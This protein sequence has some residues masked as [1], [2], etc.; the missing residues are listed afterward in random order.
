MGIYGFVVKMECKM[1]MPGQTTTLI[2]NCLVIKCGVMT[3]Y[4]NDYYFIVGLMTSLWVS[5]HS[6]R[7]WI[8][9]RP[10][11]P[12][13]AKYNKVQQQIIQIGCMDDLMC[14]MFLLHV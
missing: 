3:Y 7:K 11:T 9:Q 6:I 14:G 8:L 1:Y 12:F 13:C 4:Y 2:Y 5:D 10:C